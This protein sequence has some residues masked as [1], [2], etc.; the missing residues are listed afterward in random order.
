MNPAANTNPGMHYSESRGETILVSE[1]NDVH[2][3]NALV[4]RG[5]KGLTLDYLRDEILKRMAL[6]SSVHT[7]PC[8][9]EP[10]PRQ[11]D[12]AVPES[13]VAPGFS[14][15]VEGSTVTIV[16]NR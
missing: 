7:Q 11:R 15:V 12:V 6:G 14:I 3:L 2:L 8:S 9:Y 10:C 13:W 1:M 16:S 5:R 4:K